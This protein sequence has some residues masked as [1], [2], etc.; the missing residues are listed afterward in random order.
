MTSESAGRRGHKLESG[1]PFRR[2]AEFPF[3]RHS[4]APDQPVAKQAAE[5][6]DPVRHATGWIEFRQRIRRIRGPVTSRFR[7]GDKS[8]AQRERWVSGEVRDGELFVAQRWNYQ[9]IN[10]SED[11][12]HFQRHLAPEPVCLNEIYS[13]KKSRLPK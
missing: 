8:G 2:H 3:E 5:N 1:R 13:G 7:D 11:T 12:R 4:H 9:K 10:V 6:R